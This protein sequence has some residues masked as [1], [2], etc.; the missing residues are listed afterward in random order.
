VL[1]GGTTFAGQTISLPSVLLRYTYQGDANLDQQV[2][3]VDFTQLAT[4]FNM[5][6]ANW[7]LGDFNNDGRVNALDFNALATNTGQV[8]PP[9]SNAPTLFGDVPVKESLWDV[10]T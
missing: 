6:N 4:N 3:T 5:A 2:N 1:G 10:L 7:S 9:P 8:A